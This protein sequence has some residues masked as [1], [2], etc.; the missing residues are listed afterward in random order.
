ML[1]EFELFINEKSNDKSPATVKAYKFS[2]ENLLA[3][4][5]IESIDQIDKLTATKYREYRDSLLAKGLSK[6]S[7]NSHFRNISSF[8]HWLYD[9]DYIKDVKAITKVKPFKLGHKE[10]FTLTEDEVR[11]MVD[12]TK[13][14]GKKLM[15]VLMFQT[16]LRRA[17]VVGIKIADISDD[18]LVVHGK[19]DKERTLDLS[20]DV[21]YLLK[22]YLNER[23]INSEY[24]FY[25]IDGGQLSVECVGLRVKGAAERAK[26]DPERIAHISA[27]TCRKTCATQLLND[28]VS[29]DVVQEVLG[30]ASITTTRNIYARTST[31]NIRTAL[32]NQKSLI[33]EHND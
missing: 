17:E 13:N 16:G 26:I 8:I 5:S 7:C 28:G 30:H 15:L 27:H 4:Y 6:S 18:K 11:A 20:G 25:G 10:I 33:G 14:L 9:Y 29:L 12:N 21:I 24:L 22:Q 1:K 3:Y 19:G 31:K 32:L 2:I 23:K